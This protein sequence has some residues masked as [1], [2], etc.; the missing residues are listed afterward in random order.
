MQTYL[1]LLREILRMY[2]PVLLP[3]HYRQAWL[4]LAFGPKGFLK[5]QESAC[6]M[7]GRAPLMQP[8]KAASA[9]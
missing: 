1:G 7:M 3:L 4:S 8:L 9:C 5:K 6:D 2:S